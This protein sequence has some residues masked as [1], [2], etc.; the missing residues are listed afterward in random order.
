MNLSET[1]FVEKASNGSSSTNPFTEDAQFKLRWFTPGK[2]ADMCGHATLAAAA[3][4]F[5]GDLVIVTQPCNYFHRH[6][7][8]ELWKHVCLLLQR[9]INRKLCILRPGVADC[10]YDETEQHKE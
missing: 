4:L 7:R 10:Q 2:E 5:Q 3:T 6:H 9:V 1:A 8:G